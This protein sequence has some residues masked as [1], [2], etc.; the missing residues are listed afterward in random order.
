MQKIPIKMCKKVNKQYL[1]V[2]WYKMVS[3]KRKKPKIHFFVCKF[4]V[5]I[6]MGIWGQ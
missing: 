6:E 4:L 1:E 5:N 3:F 2:N